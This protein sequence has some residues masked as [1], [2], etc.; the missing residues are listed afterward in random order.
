MYKY[1]RDLPALIFYNMKKTFWLKV[2][3]RGSNSQMKS[4]L[5]N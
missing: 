3:L 4:K 2:N 5:R 1:K